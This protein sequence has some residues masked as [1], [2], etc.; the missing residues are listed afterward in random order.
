METSP[1]SDI[2][3]SITSTSSLVD[4]GNKS[5][6][7]KIWIYILIL[8]ALFGIIYYFL[9]TNSEQEH[10][11]GGTLSQMFANDM[12]DI[13]LTGGNMGIVDQTATGNF[14]LNFNHP[15]RIASGSGYGNGAP[16]RGQLVSTIPQVRLKSDKLL[17][18]NVPGILNS[19]DN[20]VFP[21]VIP[22]STVSTYPGINNIL[23]NQKKYNDYTEKE[24]S[25][26]MN[27]DLSHRTNTL[28]SDALNT[29]QN[30]LVNACQY[31][32]PGKCK[33][34][35]VCLN[36][37]MN[38]PKADSVASNKV[39]AKSIG[40]FSDEIE[41]M[42]V[43][44]FDSGITNNSIPTKIHN[45]IKKK[46]V[47]RC[48]N[49]DSGLQTTTTMP[50]N[51]NMPMKLHKKLSDR[52][53]KISC[54]RN[55]ENFKNDNNDDVVIVNDIN[56]GNEDLVN[57]P[58]RANTNGC[59]NCPQGRCINCPRRNGRN[60]RNN[61]CSD[62]PLGYPCKTC[63]IM[64][65]LNNRD[66]IVDSDDIRENF[67]C[68]CRK[69]LVPATNLNQKK[70]PEDLESV[71]SNKRGVKD[72]LTDQPV[73]DDRD[74]FISNINNKENFQCSLNQKSNECNTCSKNEIIT[75]EKFESS[76]GFDTLC[77]CSQGRCA[78][79]PLC[80]SGNCQN[81]PK[82]EPEST[83]IDLA[84]FGNWH[85]GSRL[86]TD[87]NEPSN[88]PAPI[89]LNNSITYYPDSYLGSYFLNPKPDIQNPYAVIPPSRTVAGLVVDYNKQK[90]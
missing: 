27:N 32:V 23:V 6:E 53:I 82:N 26:E 72:I 22:N 76:V 55:Q 33:G 54:K 18:V 87:W 86:G 21:R 61:E 25:K 74:L 17:S 42:T 49:F 2:L 13:N 58:L 40:D 83:Y 75:R 51:S 70:L 73:I 41:Y 62:C 60:G 84:S 24:L 30:S 39:D 43:E 15:T 29:L 12:Q 44:N 64:K 1:T 38:N 65:F 28:R 85:G 52:L 50:N 81:C 68:P 31:C 4:S 8:L 45:K 77:P 9:S 88:A 67:G 7:S 20:S 5:V 69:N 48:E 56:D 46:L 89:N 63:N 59:E 10:M 79:C 36:A 34:C 90:K 35:P 37:T 80:R 57:E 16:N 47:K 14:L 71:Q 78:N 66:Q 11:S 3:D 19:V